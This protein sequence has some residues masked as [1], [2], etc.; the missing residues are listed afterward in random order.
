MTVHKNTYLGQENVPKLAFSLI[1]DKSQSDMYLNQS[2]PGANETYFD[3]NFVV[4]LEIAGEDGT[5]QI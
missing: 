2:I 5:E 3:N 4:M 1:F